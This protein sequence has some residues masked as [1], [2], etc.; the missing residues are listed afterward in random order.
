MAHWVLLVGVCL[1]GG[2]R[3]KDRVEGG[4]K[5]ESKLRE[6]VGCTKNQGGEDR[7]FQKKCLCRFHRDNSYMLGLKSRT[8]DLRPRPGQGQQK[9]KEAQSEG[10]THEGCGII[11]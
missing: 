4:S 9:D 6:G 3:E 7:E 2:G 11:E 10:C 1:R 8:K 5:G